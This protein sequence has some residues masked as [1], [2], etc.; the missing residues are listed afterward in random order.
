MK[1]TLLTISVLTV[2]FCTAGMYAVS[3]SGKSTTCE[4]V[5]IELLH[6]VDAEYINGQQADDIYKRCLS[7]SQ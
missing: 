5:Y 1:L 3:T 6:A 2:A 7:A 4:E